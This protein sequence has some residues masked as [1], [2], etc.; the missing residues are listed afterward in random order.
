MNITDFIR[1]ARELSYTLDRYLITK[2]RYCAVT[3][4]SGDGI[5]VAFD[6]SDRSALQLHRHMK[7]AFPDDSVVMSYEPLNEQYKKLSF[8]GEDILADPAALAENARAFK[9][10][11]FEST[12]EKYISKATDKHYH[13]IYTCEGVC[14]SGHSI[15]EL[16][17]SIFRTEEYIKNLSALCDIRSNALKSTADTAAIIT[18]RFKAMKSGSLY[19]RKHSQTS[20]NE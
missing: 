11:L 6:R 13:V 8:A 14:V 4:F 10:G 2:A 5:C 20:K 16:E 18:D 12:E 1:S 7:K 9:Q 19:L 15:K 3:L 17:D